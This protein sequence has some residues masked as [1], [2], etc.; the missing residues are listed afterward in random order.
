MATSMPYSIDDAVLDRI[1]TVDDNVLKGTN[2]VNTN[3]S[4]GFCDTNGKVLGTGSDIRRDVANGFCDTNGKIASAECDLDRDIYQ[5]SQK[6][7]D[8]LGATMERKSIANDLNAFN[9]TNNILGSV[10]QNGQ[11]SIDATERNGTGNLISTMTASAQNLAA[12]ER[13]NS[14]NLVATDRNGNA[15]MLSNERI[16]LEN[17]RLGRDM[18]N[19]HTLHNVDTLKGM[20]E[21]NANIADRYCKTEERHNDRH[22]RLELELAR[23]NAASQLQGSENYSRLQLELCKMDNNLGKD[24]LKTSADA[25][26]QSIDNLRQ[27]QLDSAKLE[28]T[29]S[30]QH[31][32]VLNNLCRME[33]KLELQAEKNTASIQ[34]EALRNRSDI[35]C[36]IDTCC[37]ELKSEIKNSDCDRLRDRNLILEFELK[38]GSGGGH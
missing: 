37:C 12:I 11:R 27:T 3:V 35:L 25:K 26:F 24:I 4:N 10:T 17:H 33:S 15:I 9:H 16:I 5:T 7:I 8:T 14:A 6:T 31:E 18:S 28:G 38:C 20:F 36:K 13:A 1:S 22:Q 21:I 23:H 29:V 30:R 34:L 2:L 19:Q 32:Q